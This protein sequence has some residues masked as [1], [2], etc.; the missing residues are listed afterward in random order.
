MSPHK[1]NAADGRP[2]GRRRWRGVTPGIPPMS[3]GR[4]EDAR[5]CGPDAYVV[6]QCSGAG[7]V[8]PRH[9]GKVTRT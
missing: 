2:D 1:S 3:L 5:R 7:G 9:R 8:V 6:Q 4:V